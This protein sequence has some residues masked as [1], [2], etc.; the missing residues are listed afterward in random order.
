MMEMR[1]LF[2]CTFIQLIQFLIIKIVYMRPY[3]KILSPTQEYNC[4]RSK[5]HLKHLYLGIFRAEAE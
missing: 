3:H 1:F 4:T 2:V 5:W